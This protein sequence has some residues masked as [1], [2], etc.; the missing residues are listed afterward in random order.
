[1]GVFEDITAGILKEGRPIMFIFLLLAVLCFLVLPPI[2]P[3]SSEFRWGISI[4][5]FL[6]GMIID[7]FEIRRHRATIRRQDELRDVRR[8]LISEIREYVESTDFSLQRFR[9]HPLFYRI[10]GDLS[11][12]CITLFESAERNIIHLTIQ[13]GGGY[14]LYSDMIFEELVRIEHKWNL[15]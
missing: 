9:R 14:S 15:L 2:Y 13:P 11:P 7:S 8:N 12:E 10:K 4:M 5:V 3:I 1:M 6:I